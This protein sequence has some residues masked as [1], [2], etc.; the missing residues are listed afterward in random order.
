MVKNRLQI[1]KRKDFQNYSSDF[2]EN[3]CN[4]QGGAD[5]TGTMI[6]LWW[7]F[8][9]FFEDGSLLHALKTMVYLF[10]SMPTCKHRCPFPICG[11][12]TKLQTHTGSFVL[13]LCIKCTNAKM[14]RAVQLIH[15]TDFTAFTEDACVWALPDGS[16]E[17]G[18]THCR[19][20]PSYSS[21]WADNSPS[22][23]YCCSRRRP[24]TEGHTRITQRYVNEIHCNHHHN[25]ADK[26][27]NFFYIFHNHYI[28]PQ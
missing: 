4:I 28:F 15:T 11:G 12:W 23:T 2:P 18:T 17:A 9:V 8:R 6:Y 26:I 13:D 19:R 21:S 20:W 16:S 10:I 5:H 24:Q 7:L 27:F 25:A 1:H 14:G 22:Q 3:F